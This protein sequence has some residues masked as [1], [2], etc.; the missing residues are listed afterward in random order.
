MRTGK[1]AF[2][3]EGPVIFPMLLEIVEGEEIP[4]RR[5]LVDKGKPFTLH[6]LYGFDMAVFFDKDQ[7]MV[8]RD[9]VQVHRP[10]EHF[11]TNF[12]MGQR[13]SKTTEE[14]TV[15]PERSEIVNTI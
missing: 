14:S 1:I 9:A 7:A 8:H 3:Q 11:D 4:C 15:H 12:C 2:L 5:S 10:C 13:V 6:L